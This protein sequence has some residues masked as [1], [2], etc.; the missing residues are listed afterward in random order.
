MF[1][2]EKPMSE[3]EL[4]NWRQESALRPHRDYLSLYPAKDSFDSELLLVEIEFWKSIAGRVSKAVRDLES[5]QDRYVSKFCKEV[6][7]IDSKDLPKGL[8]IFSELPAKL[9]DAVRAQLAE[10]VRTSSTQSRSDLSGLLNEVKVDLRYFLPT[11]NVTINSK[12]GL[13]GF[14]IAIGQERLP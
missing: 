2:S 7:G 14:G 6:L 12:N 9:Q 1:P 13:H 8:T 3:D 4:T 11:L 5:S 10:S